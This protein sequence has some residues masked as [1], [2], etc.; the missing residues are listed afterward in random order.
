MANPR[1]SV[2]QKQV[3][4]RRMELAIAW[5]KYPN[6]YASMLQLEEGQAKMQGN[7]EGL[8]ND[9]KALTG[10]LKAFKDEVTTDLKEIKDI[11]SR[12]FG[13]GKNKE[14]KVRIY[15]PMIGACIWD[16]SYPVSCK[17]LMPIRQNIIEGGTNPIVPSPHA[18]SPCPDL[19][20]PAEALS[21]I[22][23]VK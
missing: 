4:D 7:L 3:K 12:N 14:G 5:T 19:Q 21:H 23:K 17:S 11:L 15:S 13:Q 16:S 2:A 9:I 10:D 18:P 8:T 20:L 22:R 1:S 6:L